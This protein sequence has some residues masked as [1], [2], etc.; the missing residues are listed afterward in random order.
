L[1]STVGEELIAC[2]LD[3]NGRMVLMIL[4][5]KTS[6]LFWAPKC[7]RLA[8]LKGDA[9][10]EQDLTIS[11]LHLPNGEIETSIQLISS[12]WDEDLSAEGVQMSDAL[13]ALSYGSISW[14]P[15]GRYLAFAGII[16]GPSSDLYIYDTRTRKVKRLTSGPNQAYGLAWSPDGKWI[17]HME[18]IS[19]T[20]WWVETVWAAASDGST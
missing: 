1:V 4:Q 16:E 6:D 20:G 17:V 19:F 3:G 5:D 14:S 15:D 2:N 8:I 12:G 18:V 7:E 11:I 13:D 10:K 9:F